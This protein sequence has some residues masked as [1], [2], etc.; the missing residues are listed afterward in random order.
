MAD[1]VRISN[2]PDSG[3]RERVAYDIWQALRYH[4]DDFTTPRD[5]IRVHLALYSQC[6]NAVSNGDVDVSEIR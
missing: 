3:S 1:N 4:V 6:L 2:M 5:A